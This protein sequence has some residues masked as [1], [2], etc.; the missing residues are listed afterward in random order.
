MKIKAVAEWARGGR[1]ASQDHPPL[2][3]ALLSIF[4][5]QGYFQESFWILGGQTKK[6]YAL[7]MR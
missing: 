7:G 4:S 5:P 3:I 1:G 2:C 6:R